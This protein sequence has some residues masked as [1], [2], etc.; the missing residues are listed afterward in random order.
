MLKSFFDWWQFNF[1]LSTA[2]LIV[3]IAV[4]SLPFALSK[5]FRKWLARSDIDLEF[6]GFIALA[7]V[8][9]SIGLYNYF[10]RSSGA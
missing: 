6:V 2:S 10:G 4:I 7:V 5:S 1:W 9:I 8:V 3:G